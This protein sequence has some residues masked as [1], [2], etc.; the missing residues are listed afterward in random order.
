[1]LTRYGVWLLTLRKEGFIVA[2]PHA[3]TMKHLAAVR[4]NSKYVVCGDGIHPNSTL[5]AQAHAPKVDSDWEIRTSAN[6]S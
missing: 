3:E 4:E 6:S 5:R 1:M 2:D